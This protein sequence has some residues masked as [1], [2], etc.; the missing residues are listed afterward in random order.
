[1]I[2]EAKRN[3]ESV[4]PL[5]PAFKAEQVMNTHKRSGKEHMVHRSVAIF[6]ENQSHICVVVEVFTIPV[7]NLKTG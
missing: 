6:C 3:P 2:K 7:S 1:V 5:S 4:F